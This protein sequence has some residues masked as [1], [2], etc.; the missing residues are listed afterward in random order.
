MGYVRCLSG[1]CVT[2][3]YLMSMGTSLLVILARDEDVRSD[4]K[5]E[6]WKGIDVF[7]AR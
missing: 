6:F 7:M 1:R 4:R 5:P 3:S 2:Q